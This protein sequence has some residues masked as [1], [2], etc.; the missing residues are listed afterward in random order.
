MVFYDRI[1]EQ[2]SLEKTWGQK[3]PQL[4]TLWGRRRVG[5]TTLLTRFAGV[6]EGLYFYGTRASE[7]DVLRGFSHQAADLLGDDYLRQAPFPNWE[8]ALS[9]LTRAMGGRRWLLVL[10]EFPYLCEVTPGLDTIVQRW[11]DELP[12]Q[13]APTVVL[14]GSGFSFMEGLVGARGPLHGRRTA[15][16]EVRPFD[17]LD[18]AHFFPNLDPADKVRAYACYGGSPAYLRHFDSAAS[19]AEN[20]QNTLLSPEHFLCREGEELLRTEFHQE[21][22][23]ASILRCVAQ[24]EHRPSDIAR[25]VGR[26]GADQIFDH[27]RRMQSLDFLRREV[28]VTELGRARSQRVLYKL[29]DPYL[30]FWFTYVAPYQSLLQLGKGKSLW[31]QEILPSLNGFVARTT[32]EEVCLQY[33]WR[34]LERNQLTAKV[35]DLGRWWEGDAELDLVGLWQGQVTLVG[36]CKWS[37]TPIDEG[38][39]RYLQERGSRLPLAAQP[40]WILASRSGFSTALRRRAASENLLLIEPSDLFA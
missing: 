35:A 16:V 14:A 33:L 9:H 32:W 28:P 40:L 22:L 30:R 7:A 26:S 27:L 21:A 13:A 11:W 23:Y 19:L 10:D 18:A 2:A 25:A 4:I 6:R 5:K 20:I 31:D 38:E 15:Q 29:S 36:E 8:T 24:G 12:E 3:G 1:R 34:L 39:L 37:N 17:Y